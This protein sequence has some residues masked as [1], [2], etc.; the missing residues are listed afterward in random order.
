[1]KNKFKSIL[2][3]VF[4]AV[5]IFSNANVAFALDYIP[6]TLEYQPELFYS[7]E[8]NTIDLSQ[9]ITD[10]EAFQADILAQ[11]RV[12]T[13]GKLDVSKYNIP[14][15]Y[16]HFVA[17]CNLIRDESPELF[18]IS[19]AGNFSTSYYNTITSI[20]VEYLFDTPEEFNKEY[21]N[22][23]KTSSKLLENIKNNETLNDVEKALLLHDRLA[24]H[25][26]YDY[27]NY[28]AN[29][30]QP[31]S[32]SAYGAICLGTAVCQG[33]AYA[34]DYLLEQVGIK[35]DYC[36]SK[37]LCHAWNIVYID[38]KPY[39]VDVTSDDPVWDITGRVLHTNFLRST[40]G[41]KSVGQHE[42][43]DYI[44][45][46]TDTTYDTYFWQ[47]SFAAFQLIN[48]EIYYIDS[49]AEK[50]YVI[51][52]ITDTTLE[53]LANLNFRWYFDKNEGTY[54]G[55]NA[56]LA[57]S[58]GL[59]YYSAPDAI[60]CYDP[61]KNETVT[62]FTPEDVSADISD[63]NFSI[64]GMTAQ[65]C[66][67]KG[68]Y[69]NTPNYDGNTKT[70]NS[71]TIELHSKANE[72][73]TVTP[74]TTTTEGEEI[75]LCT[76]CG[77]TVETRVIPIVTDHTC[78]WSEWTETKPTCTEDGK[79]QRSCSIC[80]TIET[81][82]IASTG[83]KPDSKF[84]IEI[85][86][87]CNASGSQYKKCLTCSAKLSIT[88]IAATGKHI[89]SD[90]KIGKEATC[91]SD[92][93]K[94]KSCN[95][96]GTET[97]REV[98]NALP[99][100]ETEIINQVSATC[101][102]TGYTG[103]TRCKECKTI[104][105]TGSATPV[106]SHKISDWIIEKQPSA[107]QTG[108]RYKKC[109]VCNTRLQEEIIPKTEHKYNTGVITTPATCTANGV[110]TFTCSVCNHQYTESIPATGHKEVIIP[111][112]PSTCTAGGSTE[113]KKCSACNAVIITPTALPKANH[114]ITLVGKKDPTF[115]AEGH[116]GAEVCSVCK[117]TINAGSVI[118]K[119]T[120]TTPVVT[121][122]ATKTG[123]KVTW[124]KVENAQSYIVYKR[125][126]N[127]ST[128]KWSGWEIIN[129]NAT[130]LSLEDSN[131][132]LGTK[133][134][135]T[136]RA[137]N[138]NTLSPYK[139]TGTVKYNVIP[140]VKVANATGGIKVSWST[141]ANATGYRVYRSTLSN[142]KWSG[143][144]N[145]GTAASNKTSWTDKS[146]KTGVTYKYTVRAV[147]NKI[148]SSYNKDGAVSLFLSTPAVKIANTATGIQ[149]KWN[150]VSGATGYIVYSAQFD[151]VTN[152]WS[153]WTN[154]GT[155]NATSWTD[156]T[157]KSGVTYK[158]TVRA[159]NGNTL[160]A[161]K[162]TGGLIYL[163][164]PTVKI[165][166]AAKGIKVKWS[167]CDGATGYT[168]YRSEYN[169]ETKKWSKWKSRGTAAATKSSWTDKKVTSGKTYKYTVRAVNGNFKSSY[170][171]T[172]SLLYL[173]QPTV[174]VKAVDNGIN[175]A[176][177]Q[178]AGATGYRVYRSELVN[179]EWSK[180]KTM[181]TAKA[182]KNS[183]T[184]KSAEKG[185]TYKYTVRTVNGKTLSSYA[186]G[187]AV[188]R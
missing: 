13:T 2:C 184:D 134:R 99:H 151:P 8:T 26:E 35:S 103:D 69:S 36:S 166:N 96:C 71:F 165:S 100:T 51:D 160:S 140:T 12:D 4:V 41:I 74:A 58:Y 138:G 167:Q 46:P 98:L 68:E 54:W 88:P 110:R 135:Y 30:L 152:K 32:H 131:V 120:F 174:T 132:V 76:K 148:L 15:D 94:Y 57:S 129:G 38:N 55:N 31:S 105:K 173:A 125:V 154:R 144:K 29:K 130:E 45:T 49:V 24:E 155:V 62:V 111:A 107:T 137:K 112:I 95:T 85:E 82:T 127:E 171:S 52:D 114:T 72:W 126:Y 22:F 142:G 64:F 93:Y 183:W 178:C 50:L 123:I 19:P 10:V 90:W 172:G 150:S 157:V 141:A 153:G 185:K 182:N 66:T 7:T 87:T 77:T 147:Y 84:T 78:E 92:G 118:K 164:E 124:N 117:Q 89:S 146:V 81:E 104:I 158:Y 70:N 161:Y 136:V 181:G 60:Y 113:G 20:S 56:R 121:A 47:N 179:G 53:T 48:N 156:T 122:V 40:E 108:L 163:V 75:L 28:K 34:Y 6:K 18:R 61:I 149:V 65:Y 101:K 102:A 139:S 91:S 80:N 11:L 5:L 145:M 67:I 27:A 109:T 97:A 17:L 180:W 133:Y 128:E 116:T 59:L 21:E 23:L 177:T 86:P 143:W 1:M 187:T 14:G 79:K 176:W 162:G 63:E 188:C 83:H 169:S 43:N 44:S 106:L 42:A 168:V 186:D 9:Y 39:H 115:E 16:E 3:L 175:V 159:L 33:Y 37:K 119:L 170:V 25:C 73:K